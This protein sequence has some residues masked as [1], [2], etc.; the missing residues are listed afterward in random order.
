MWLPEKA[1]FSFQFYPNPAKDI[2]YIESKTNTYKPLYYEMHDMAGKLILKGSSRTEKIEL[3]VGKYAR[4]IYFI[5]LYNGRN[6]LMKQT[7]IVLQ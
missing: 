5:K 2:L 1:E 3:P 6:I 4:G 7:K